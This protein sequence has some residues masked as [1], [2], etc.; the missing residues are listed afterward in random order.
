MSSTLSP[1]YENLQIDS[2]VFPAAISFRENTNT[3]QGSAFNWHEAIEIYYILEG[4]LTLNTNGTLYKLEK[5]DIGIVGWGLPHRGFDFAEVTKHYIIQ[6]DI[7]AIP[8]L[9]VYPQLLLPKSLANAAIRGDNNASK[10]LDEV[11]LSY[12]SNEKGSKLFALAALLKFFAI[13]LRIDSQVKSEALEIKADSL[14]H[15]HNMLHYMNNHFLE[16]V[17]LDELSRNLGLSKSYMCRLFKKHIGQTIV[18]HL[19]ER[20]CHYAYALIADGMPLQNAALKSGFSDY[21]YFSR[22]FK[23]IMGKRPSEES[24]TKPN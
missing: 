18:Y 24:G 8:Q 14:K 21:N 11:I 2:K 13:V 1:I 10:L 12:K 5:G 9:A 7:S 19:N 3:S 15:I 23:Q 6:V 16:P 4:S 17:T 20:R 22:T